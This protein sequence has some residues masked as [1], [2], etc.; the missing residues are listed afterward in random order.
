MQS[1]QHSQKGSTSLTRALLLVML[2]LFAVTSALAQNLPDVTA[3]SV[4]DL[5]NVQVTSV[6]KRSQKLADAAAAI[7]RDHPRGH[8]PLGRQQHSGGIANGSWCAGGTH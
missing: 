5:M 1:I 7:L 6:S 3:M 4:E 2:V 8:P